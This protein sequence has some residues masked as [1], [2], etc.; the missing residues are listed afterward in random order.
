MKL[1]PIVI[2]AI[3]VFAAFGS[4]LAAA[5]PDWNGT[6]IGNWDKGGNGIQIVFAGNT[7][8]SFFWKGDYLSDAEGSVSAD[9]TSA[10]IDWS[11]GKAVV[12]REGEKTAHIVIREKNKPEA[13]FALKR[14]NE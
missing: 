4:T 8:I 14:D 9:G 5:K 10:T 13:A 2:R 6:W 3:L 12:T 7:F 11:E 1:A